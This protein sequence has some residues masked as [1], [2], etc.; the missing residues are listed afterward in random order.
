[1][2]KLTNSE[3]AD[4]LHNMSAAELWQL[5]ED[6]EPIVFD[7]SKKDIHRVQKIYDLMD[8]FDSEY[9]DVAYLFD[10]LETPLKMAQYLTDNRRLQAHLTQFLAIEAEAEREIYHDQ[11][12]A[13]T[14]EL[15]EQEQLDLKQA[16]AQIPQRLLDRTGSVIH[17]LKEEFMAEPA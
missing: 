11:F 1:M 13:N 3:V 14:L 9:E 5:N 4:I 16:K 2:N 15:P 17:F 7:Y 8:T 6:V 12:W 10:T